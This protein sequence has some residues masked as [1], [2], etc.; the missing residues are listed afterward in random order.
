VSFAQVW[1]M[2]G[3][4]VIIICSLDYEGLFLR[5]LMAFGWQRG[6]TMYPK[7]NKGN[8]AFMRTV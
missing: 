6:L 5:A 3:T 4:Q 1:R 8:G 2:V 7:G